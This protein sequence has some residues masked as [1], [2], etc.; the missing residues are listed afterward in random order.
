VIVSFAVL[1]TVEVDPE[2]IDRL[3]ALFDETNRDL[4]A[5]RHD[6]LGAWFTADRERGEVTVQYRALRSRR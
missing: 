2:S 3:A 6:R 5:R 4:V 1:T